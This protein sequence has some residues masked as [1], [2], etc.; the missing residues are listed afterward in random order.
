MFTVNHFISEKVLK[1]TRYE[2]GISAKRKLRSGKIAKKM[3]KRPL[4]IV[5]ICPSDN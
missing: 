2:N 5:I 1:R 3:N 4:T